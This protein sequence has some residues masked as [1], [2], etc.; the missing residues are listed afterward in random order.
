MGCLGTLSKNRKM[1]E[2]ILLLLLVVLCCQM[3]GNPIR[4]SEARDDA[5]DKDSSSIERVFISDRL[6]DSLESFYELIDTSDF[7]ILA[8]PGKKYHRVQDSIHSRDIITVS[9][10]VNDNDTI[11]NF[12]GRHG[13]APPISIGMGKI[14]FNDKV[15]IGAKYVNKT[16]V[17]VNSHGHFPLDQFLDSQFI[18]S[19]DFKLYM[20][21][22]SCDMDVTGGIIPYLRSYIINGDSLRVEFTNDKNIE[23][24]DT[25]INSLIAQ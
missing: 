13:I 7:F 25:V 10:I 2:P 1:R 6:Q 11:I 24:L 9:F 20:D 19:L 15:D 5:N 22:Y 17:A 3:C 16:L 8:L 14:F 4:N 12:S 23:C 18:D 21:R